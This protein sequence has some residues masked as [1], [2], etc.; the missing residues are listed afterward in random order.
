MSISNN[1]NGSSSL[2]FTLKTIRE[3][4]ED[5]LEIGFTGLDSKTYHVAG[6]VFEEPTGFFAP[7]QI[8][9]QKFLSWAWGKI[10]IKLPNDGLSSEKVN[11]FVISSG[12]FRNAI[13][14]SPKKAR[15]FQDLDSSQALEEIKFSYFIET[16]FPSSG[17]ANM[18]LWQRLGP[19]FSDEIK[20][21]LQRALKDPENWSKVPPSLLKSSEQPE[22]LQKE[23]QQ[24]LLSQ[25][26]SVAIKSICLGFSKS[27]LDIRQLFTNALIK[28][29]TESNWEEVKRL[30]IRIDDLEPSELL[31]IID[32]LKI[33]LVHAIRTK[34]VDSMNDLIPYALKMGEYIMPFLAMIDFMSMEMLKEILKSIKLNR[35]NLSYSAQQAVVLTARYLAKQTV[36][37]AAT[38]GHLDIIQEILSGSIPF[39]YEE[40]RRDAVLCAIKAKH[41]TVAKAL[42]SSGGKISNEDCKQAIM[43]ASSQMDS[44]PELIIKLIKGLDLTPAEFSHYLVNALLNA[45]RANNLQAAQA[46]ID[47]IPQDFEFSPEINQEFSYVIP[48]AC[49]GNNLSLLEKILNKTPKENAADYRLV[50]ALYSIQT[51]NF[52]FAKEILE[53]NAPLRDEVIED[54]LVK[55]KREAFSFVL[56]L[57]KPNEI[58]DE[59]LQSIVQQRDLIFSPDVFL[60]LFLSN[61]LTKSQEKLLRDEFKGYIS[62][63]SRLANTTTDNL[64]DKHQKINSVLEQLSEKKIAYDYPFDSINQLVHGNFQF[65]F[66]R[67]VLIDFPKDFLKIIADKDLPTKVEYLGEAGIDAG[68]LSRDLIGRLI[69]GLNDQDKGILNIDFDLGLPR[70]KESSIDDSEKSES[71]ADFKRFGNFL[72]KLFELN[73]SQYQ[74]LI[75]DGYSE[76]EIKAEYSPNVIG[77]CFDSQLFGLLKVADQQEVLKNAV[78]DHLKK[79]LFEKGELNG[80]SE[81]VSVSSASIA[82]PDSWVV[83]TPKNYGNP[84][85]GENVDR[86]YGVLLEA[87]QALKD[88]QEGK[89]FENADEKI[90]LIK[91]TKKELVDA[92]VE[93]GNPRPTHCVFFSGNPSPDQMLLAECVTTDLRYLGSGFEDMSSTSFDDILNDY[94]GAIKEIKAGLSEVGMGAIIDE[95]EE[96]PIS[97][98]KQIQGEAATIDSL[99]DALQLPLNSTPDMQTQKGWIKEWLEKDPD[100]LTK[101]IKSIAGTNQLPPGKNISLEAKDR[102][103]IHTCFFSMD[104][105]SRLPQQVT[106]EK[107]FDRIEESISNRKFTDA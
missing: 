57:Y 61:K 103:F 21:N 59:V 105:Y 73:L 70:L 40:F 19:P 6:T 15:S 75:E 37:L 106:K 31:W 63:Q 98:S 36:V 93:A 95:L 92:Y 32:P 54:S 12:N 10:T 14:N 97:L 45:M 11:T 102:I 89:S 13:F 107:F 62:V 35:I 2:N 99:M 48:A 51:K 67:Q 43:D 88:I 44:D 76:D 53:S 34:A 104:L 90:A 49:N 42:I 58:P 33:V 22:P 39:S 85:K 3:G 27:Q 94:C 56:G 64:V 20:K 101:F 5:C 28:A 80:W 18:G 77:N 79:R 26:D 29:S 83:F 87:Q 50:A 60:E 86:L 52:L 84:S 69:E 47:E 4:N 74:E 1:P 8:I 24:I 9:W 100:N 55:S 71:K 25:L 7:L 23:V 30:I 82:G 65:R 72:T 68:G 17:Q 91:Q 96:N 66:Y 38:E 16:F 41:Y 46:I 78:K 81:K